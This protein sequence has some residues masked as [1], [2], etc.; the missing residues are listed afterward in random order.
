M[1]KLLCYS[2]LLFPFHVREEATES[3]NSL[4]LML[5]DLCTLFKTLKRMAPL[6]KHW[7]LNDF[8]LSDDSAFKM[9]EMLTVQS[10]HA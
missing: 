6:L 10:N 4:A 1:V 8:E 3:K 9:L 2:F 7:R 5:G